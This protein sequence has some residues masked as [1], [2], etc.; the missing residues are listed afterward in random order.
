MASSNEHLPAYA[1]LYLA[2]LFTS[3]I[4][5]TRRVVSRFPCSIAL[6]AQSNLTR[7]E[8]NNGS[9]PDYRHGLRSLDA[10]PAAL[11]PLKNFFSDFLDKIISIPYNSG[12]HEQEY[13]GANLCIRLTLRS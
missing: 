9:S 1:G 2:R 13:K 8:E 12:E 7:K 6:Q 10:L 11:L 3:A 5:C 4:P